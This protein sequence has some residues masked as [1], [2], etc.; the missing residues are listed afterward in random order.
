MGPTK[1]EDKI[2]TAVDSALARR[3]D[4]FGSLSTWIGIVITLISITVGSVVWAYNQTSDLKTWTADQDSVIKKEVTETIEKHYVSKS[5]FVRV[6]QKL[7]D[8]KETMQEI[9]EK[10]DRLIEMNNRPHNGR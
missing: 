4:P 2:D 3:K 5:D 7:N 10:I 9:K 1:I 6:E 8:Q